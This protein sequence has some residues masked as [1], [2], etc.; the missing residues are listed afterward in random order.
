MET[1]INLH[2]SRFLFCPTQISKLCLPSS[3]NFGHLTIFYF[4]NFRLLLSGA[5]K[6]KLDQ[7]LKY[8]KSDRSAKYI[9][10]SDFF[11]SHRGQHFSYA[12]KI[13]FFTFLSC[14]GLVCQVVFLERTFDYEFTSFAVQ[15][16]F[17]SKYFTLLVK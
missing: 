6:G 2:K 13:H 4:T 1:Y 8:L 14:I 12:L 7:Y 9:E 3:L 15:Q 11:K 5:E 16:I 10:V 17:N